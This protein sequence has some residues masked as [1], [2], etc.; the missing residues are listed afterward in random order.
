MDSLW[1]HCIAGVGTRFVHQWGVACLTGFLHSEPLQGVLRRRQ[2]CT[3]PCLFHTHCCV[4]CTWFLPQVAA[5]VTHDR[6]H[7]P[8]AGVG[9]L[10]CVIPGFVFLLQAA[11]FA[12]SSS[13]AFVCAENFVP[14]WHWLGHTPPLLSML[15]AGCSVLV[16]TYVHVHALMAAL[17]PTAPSSRHHRCAPALA[18]AVVHL[19]L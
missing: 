12:G 18:V 10:D 2:V 11:A 7:A 16:C 3:Q 8:V 14:C 15:M 17:S 4:H 13:F 6:C 9:R 5:L 19:M 1:Q